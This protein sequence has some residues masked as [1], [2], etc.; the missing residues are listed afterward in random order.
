MKKAYTSFVLGITFT[1]VLAVCSIALAKT[2]FFSAWHIS[3]LILGIVLSIV[4]ASVLRGFGVRIIDECRSGVDFSGKK[5]LRLGIILYGF[6]VSLADIQSVGLAG[7]GVAVAVVAGILVAGFVIGVKIFRLDRELAIL[8]SA[9]C[10]I[11]GAAAVLAL[12]SAVA[13]VAGILVAG[14]VIGVKIFRLDRELAILMSAGCAICGAAAVLALESALRANAQKSAI[15]IGSVVVFGLLGMFAYPIVYSA[16]LLPFSVSQMG[17][18]MGASLYEVANVVGASDVLGQEGANIALIEKMIRVALLAPV[19]FIVP[20]LFDRYGQGKSAK[21]LYIP[22]FAL[23]FVAVVIL[24]SFVAIPEAIVGFAQFACMLCL[25]MAMCALGLQ[26]DIKTMGSAKGVFGF[27][28]LL[29]VL[30]S[31]LGFGLVWILA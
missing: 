29:F 6:F 25:S 2:S 27:G 24:H 4:V 18:Y 26:I 12:E 10:A 28:L 1:L 11:C 13:V 30:V 3:P 20:F 21:K 14:F 15:A 9:G 7:V 16:G 5:L 22:Y 17:L 23:G 31:G 8:M 19:L